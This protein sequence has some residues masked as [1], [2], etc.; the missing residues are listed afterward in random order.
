MPYYTGTKTVLTLRKYVDGQATTETK[1]NSASDPDY[2]P[3]FEDTSACP[4]GAYTITPTSSLTIWR[5]TTGG[6]QNPPTGW[7]TASLA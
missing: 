7:S 3:P 5:N 2:I 1:A 6:G 4:I